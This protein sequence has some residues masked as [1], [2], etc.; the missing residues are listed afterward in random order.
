M[1]QTTL[2]AAWGQVLEHVE[3]A[4]QQAE[5]QAIERERT[6]L[7]P[8]VK[9]ARHEDR[10]AHWQSCLMRMQA[11][12]QGLQSGM[13]RLE[14]KVQEADAELQQGEEALQQWLVGLQSLGRDLAKWAE[15]G[16]E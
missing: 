9:F 11:R 3:L 15:R 8:E 7:A 1:L 2:P 12:T 13:Q 10:E 14:Q 4:L 6:L 16:V 5:A